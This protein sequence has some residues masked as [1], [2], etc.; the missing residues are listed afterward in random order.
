VNIVPAR[1]QEYVNRVDRNRALW[2]GISAGMTALWSVYR[3]FW[4][5]YSATVLS[6]VGLS[7]ASLVFSFVLWGAVGVAAALVSAAFLLRYAKQ[8]Q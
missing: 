1:I 7:P 3:L 4:L 5:F 8:P 6:S 2:I